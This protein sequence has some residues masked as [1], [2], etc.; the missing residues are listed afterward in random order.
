MD[1]T[2][3]LP[4]VL[5]VVETAALIGALVFS[6]KGIREKKDATFRKSSMTQSGI[7]FFVYLV[8]NM[9]RRT[10]FGV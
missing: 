1:F 5:A 8:L 4:N 3:I 6:A 2:T 10:Y 9:I 7:F